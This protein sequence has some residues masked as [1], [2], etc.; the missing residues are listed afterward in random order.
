MP[1]QSQR[2]RRT[3][4]HADNDPDETISRRRQGRRPNDS[5]E[6]SGASE[7]EQEDVSM[8]QSGDGA[9]DLLANKLVRYA[10][11]CEYARMPIKRDGIRDKVLGNNARL[12][13]RVFDGAQTQL[14]QVFGMEMAEL[15]VK[16]KRTLKE[17][18]KA[19]ARKATSQAS[20]SSRQYILVSILP[21]EYKA[22]AIIAPARVPSSQEEA[23]YIGF[24]TMIVSLIVLSGGELSDMKLRR[25]LGRM[26]ASQNLPMDKTDNVLQK[27]V[28]QGYVDKVVEKSEG[29]EDTVTW[30]VGS[31]GRVEIP[32]QSI[33]AF[34]TEVWG[35]LPDDFNKKLAKSLGLQEARQ[36]GEDGAE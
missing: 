16:E 30:C 31:R 27:L 23:S 33:A 8:D 24:Y 2:R 34:V 5:D 28:R 13:R 21:A 6:D 25:H 26:N 17:K 19:T 11:A 1:P 12:F 36:D 14:R 4:N 35:E 32:P 20:Q 3:G 7:A 15:P 29:D 22:H 18:Q 9:E 10:L